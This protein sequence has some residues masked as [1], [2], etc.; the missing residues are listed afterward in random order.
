MP[1]KI[2]QVMRVGI[3]L[4]AAEL[5]V[6]MAGAAV[7][8]RLTAEEL[9]AQSE[10]IVR[11][12]VTRSWAAWDPVHK[13]IWTHYEIAVSENI[14][15]PHTATI[16]VS[17]PGGTLDGVSMQTSGTLPFAAGEDAVLFLYKTPIGYWRV[18]GGP[19]GKF[20]VEHDGRVRMS[21]NGVAFVDLGSTPAKG[22]PLGSL[23]GI[24]AADFVSR[25]RGL[26]A[27]HPLRGAQ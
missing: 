3:L 21:A 13:Y 26:A 23:E 6:A 18:A 9:T 24:A 17:E 8:P 12:R 1:A 5:A 15:G 20:I 10:R 2:I 22:I 27:A 11:G 7:A 19:Q 25:V 16:T 4:A 14:R